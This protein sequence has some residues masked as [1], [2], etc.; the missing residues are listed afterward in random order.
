MRCGMVTTLPALVPDCG[1][2][3]VHKAD[4]HGLCTVDSRSKGIRL[5]VAKTDIDAQLV[6]FREE[7]KK[8]GSREWQGPDHPCEGT[9]ALWARPADRTCEEH[10]GARVWSEGKGKFGKPGGKDPPK[11][12]KGGK[13]GA[14]KP[15]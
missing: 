7:A 6:R 10:G 12:A 2:I 13:G 14:G 4:K 3:H 1:I 11:G 8:K 5:T 15:E 9:T